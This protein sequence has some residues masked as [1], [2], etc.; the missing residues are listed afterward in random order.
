MR[1]GVEVR[2][3]RGMRNFLNMEIGLK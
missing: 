3:S 2:R 1:G